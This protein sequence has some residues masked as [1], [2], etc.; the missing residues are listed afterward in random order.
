MPPACALL[1]MVTPASSE[2]QP[3]RFFDLPIEIRYMVYELLVDK[4]VNI[5]LPDVKRSHRIINRC[6]SYVD[7][8][9]PAMMRVN[10]QVRYEYITLV[11]PR[12]MLCVFWAIRGCRYLF[13]RQVKQILPVRIFSQLKFLHL[14][15][16][17]PSPHP[18]ESQFSVMKHSTNS[19]HRLSRCSV[20]DLRA[21]T[22]NASARLLVDRHEILAN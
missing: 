7:C 11:I 12:M 4:S 10:K 8:Y 5:R 16:V 15:I 18:S 2:M 13:P 22:Q 19:T 14:D 1:G 20:S 9:H 3:F 6:S 17:I 21:H